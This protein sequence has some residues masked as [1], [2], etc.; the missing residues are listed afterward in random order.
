V[1]GLLLLAL[2]HA[3]ERGVTAAIVLV[4]CAMTTWGDLR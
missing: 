4:A 1:A 3:G 2:R